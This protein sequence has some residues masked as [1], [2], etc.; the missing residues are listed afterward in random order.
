MSLRRTI[1]PLPKGA[2]RSDS[3]R[4]APGGPAGFRGF[5]DNPLKASRLLSRSLL[6][7]DFQESS[8]V[9]VTSASL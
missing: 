8:T 3:G 4:E 5:H 6:A 9:A 1:P 2:A 7:P